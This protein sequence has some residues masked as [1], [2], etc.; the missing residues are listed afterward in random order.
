MK[1]LLTPAALLLLVGGTLHAVTVTDAS[2]Y[3]VNGTSTLVT[4]AVGA[5]VVYIANP[6]T[7]SSSLGWI[8]FKG[9][10]STTS[11][12]HSGGNTL[13]SIDLIDLSS[14]NS[15]EGNFLAM[16]WGVY[17]N[18]NTSEQGTHRVGKT[19]GVSTSQGWQ[20]TF[21]TSSLLADTQ[22]LFNVH[23]GEYSQANAT[24]SMLFGGVAQKSGTLSSLGYAT[25]SAEGIIQIGFT[26]SQAEID[27]GSDMS[28]KL[29][30]AGGGGNIQTAGAFLTAVPE[31]STYG[32]IGGF[33]ALVGVV[34]LRR[35]KTK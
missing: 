1:S 5:P 11:N 33:A 10:P 35:R 31:P 3:Q 21:D 13:I 4:T 25:A 18:T 26:L 6:T 23:A 19:Q 27:A 32:L 2:I 20:Y 17:G 12:I 29:I 30:G 14:W 8:A 16:N 28:F 34:G 15:S 9:V 24:W 22:Y 7:D